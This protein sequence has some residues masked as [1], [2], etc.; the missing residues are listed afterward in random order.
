MNKKIIVWKGATDVELK[1]LREDIEKKEFT[2]VG[3]DKELEVYQI[4]DSEIFQVVNDIKKLGNIEV[5]G[6]K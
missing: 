6:K 3:G 2:L 1:Q 5:T 4:I